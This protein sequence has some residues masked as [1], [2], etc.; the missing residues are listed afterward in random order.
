ML[1]Q[2]RKLVFLDGAEH[3]PESSDDSDGTKCASL[4]PDQHEAPIAS[5]QGQEGQSSMPKEKQDDVESSFV[6]ASSQNPDNTNAAQASTPS[7]S[8]SDDKMP[9]ANDGKPP[10]KHKRATPK[11]KG[12]KQRKVQA[13]PKQSAKLHRKEAAKTSESDSAAPNLRPLCST[14]AKKCKLAQNG[15]T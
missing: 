3:G 9:S 8:D 4:T 15:I 7:T 5:S 14:M 10:S 12:V 2:Y 1:S 11:K 6:S 13:K